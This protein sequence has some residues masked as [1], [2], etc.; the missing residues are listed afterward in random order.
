MKH[1][2]Q[3]SLCLQATLSRDIWGRIHITFINDL[4]CGP[5]VHFTGFFFLSRGCLLWLKELWHAFLTYSRLCP[6]ERNGDDERA[7]FCKVL[8]FSRCSPQLIPASTFLVL[9]SL[10]LSVFVV[11]V[12][13]GICIVRLNVKWL[14]GC[15]FIPK[16]M[17]ES[18]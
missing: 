3:V 5:C 14:R 4:G 1:I 10:L 16:R 11:S 18:E 6:F 12:T 7:T 8:V 2:H 9:A 15:I 17:I 13:T